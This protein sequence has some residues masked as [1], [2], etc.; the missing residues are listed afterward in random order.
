MDLL[1]KDD[2][3]VLLLK[4]RPPCVSFFLPTHRGGGEADP[5]RSLLW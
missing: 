4:G 2:L 5:I 1:T 3:K